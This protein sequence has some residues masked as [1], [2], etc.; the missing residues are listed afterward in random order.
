[1]TQHRKHSQTRLALWGTFLVLLSSLGYADSKPET[2]VDGYRVIEWTDLMPKEDLDALLNPP[3]YISEVEDGSLADQITSQM[4]M[5]MDSTEE[6]RYQQALSSTKIIPAFDQQKVRLPGFIVPLEFN[7]AM[8]ATEFFLV[9]YFGACLHM[10]PPPPN[11]I[12]YV[13]YPEGVMLESLERPVWVSGILSTE[14]E[15][16][17]IAHSAYSMNAKATELY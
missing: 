15:I 5:V 10:P 12:I 8:V 1:M 16:N 3:E 11:Q 7:D 6:D 9:P 4:K 13:K 17:D 2:R 14:Q